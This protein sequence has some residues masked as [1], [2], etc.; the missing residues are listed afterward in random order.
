MRCRHCFAHFSDAGH[1]NLPQAD[2]LAVVRELAQGFDRINFVGGEPTLCPWLE[3]ALQLTRDLGLAASI[4][5][6]GSPML[7]HPP[8]ASAI[9]T[10]V[11][12]VG[13]S[14]DSAVATTNRT[15]GRTFGNRVLTANDMARLAD[16]IHG[17][18]VQ[19]KINTVVQRAN[20][21]E[22]FHDLLLALRPSRWKV[23]RVLPVAGQND[24]D[25]R[26][27]AVTPAEFAAFVDRHRDLEQHGL[28]LR[29]EDHEA[30]TGSYAMVDPGGF[31]FDN[32]DG[33][34]RYSTAPI[35]HLGWQHAFAQV[36]LLPERFAARGGDRTLQGGAR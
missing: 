6:N 33:R 29:P 18:N 8:L 34:Y 5:T 23:F 20:L 32:I 11:D 36:R 12:E 25:Y 2:M 27:L 30:M 7:R 19:L 1:D 4:V 31:A 13:L 22:D 10:Q 14:I 17:A 35:H 16:Q 24:A 26:D 9:L 21:A 3:S 28:Q 15:I